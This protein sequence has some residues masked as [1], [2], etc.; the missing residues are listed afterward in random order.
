MM[1]SENVEIEDNLKSP[2]KLSCEE[3]K[4]TIFCFMP[5]VG[6]NQ[7]KSNRTG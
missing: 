2:L 7:S 6:E 1:I 4:F 3:L 5:T